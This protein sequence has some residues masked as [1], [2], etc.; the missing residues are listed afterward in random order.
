MEVKYT[1]IRLKNVFHAALAPLSA[2]ALAGS[3]FGVSATSAGAVAFAPMSP[4]EYQFLAELNADRAA[5]GLGALGANGVLSG[6]ARQRSQQM[7]ASG[8]FSHYDGAGNL[9]FAGLLNGAGFPYAFAGENLAENNY[10]WG[11]SLDQANAALMN[12]T[13]HRA[14]ILNTR[15]NQVGVGI[16]GPD[17]NGR[18]YYT[19]L[20][21]QAW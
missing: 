7:L 3:I 19:Q 20:F 9:I 17:G 15:F 4:P 10:P 14:N 2:L 11:Q 16:A 6:L 12:S 8:S 5:N 13:T 21:A 1:L 18:F